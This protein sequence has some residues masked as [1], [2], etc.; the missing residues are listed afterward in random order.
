MGNAFQLCSRRSFIGG[1]AALGAVRPLASFASTEPLLRMGVLSDIH[2]QCKP[3]SERTFLKA[4][5]YFRSR[6]AD[7]VMIAGD[8]ANTGRIAELKMCADAW[9]SVFPND[10]GEDGRKVER[11]FV[12]GNHCVEAWKWG[13]QYTSPIKDEQARLADALGYADNR[14]KAWRELFHEEFVPI[15]MKSVRGFTV[16]GAHWE[17]TGEG[18]GI[19]AF[20]KAHA[21]DID[22]AKPFFY[23]QHE[24]PKDTCFG[25]WAWGHDDGRSTRALSAFPN[26][27][28]FSGHSHY[29]LT[30]ERTVWQGAFTSCNTAS[31]YDFSMDYALRDNAPGNRFGYTGDKGRIRRMSNM[32]SSESR[33]GQFLTV[34]ADRIV[35]ERRDFVSDLSLG[36]DFVLPLPLGSE[37]PCAFAPRCAARVAPEFPN[38]AKAEVVEK[39][40][41]KSGMLYEISFP[42]AE[43]RRKC[44]VFEYE[45]TA[46]LVEDGV[47][48]VQAQRRVIAPDFHLADI[49]K[50]HR[51][52]VCVIAAADLPLKGTYQFIVRPVECFGRKGAGIVSNLIAIP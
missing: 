36:D 38:G 41:D 9:F 49:P 1:I 13:R 52:G 5:R 17:K 20:M 50:C 22:P 7:A 46:T 2:L 16:I 11:L 14:R 24:H 39:K 30:D 42:H 40:D 45:V 19:E 3:G 51:R 8:I 4:L 23:V 44:R 10:E 47:D 25:P 26:A 32:Q 43:T 21:K 34:Y 37:K 35:I 18:I 12:L 28:A 6:G 33:Q 31:L 15:W 29:S 48:L 27:V